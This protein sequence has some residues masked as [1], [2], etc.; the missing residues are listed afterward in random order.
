MNAATSP[1]R[2]ANDG[3]AARAAAWPVRAVL[4]I[5][6]FI[7][8]IERLTIIA[9]MAL[10]LALILLNVVT[11][12]SGSSIYWVDESAV[13]S[14]VWLAFIG[15]SAMTRLRLDVAMSMLTDKLSPA[16]AGRAKVAAGL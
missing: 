12:Y 8:R 10:L 1:Q 9:L 4:A 6:A 7:L 14:V 16:W 5:S 11:R 3:Q 15:G 2:P 13:F